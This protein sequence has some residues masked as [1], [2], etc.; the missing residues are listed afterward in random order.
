MAEEESPD[1]EPVRARKVPREDARPQSVLERQA[2][3][4]GYLLRRAQRR[5][6]RFLERSRMTTIGRELVRAGYLTGCILFDFLV[7]PEPIF[8]F[9]GDLA[10]VVTGVAFIFAIGVEAWFYSKHFALPKEESE[11]T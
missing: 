11:E 2:S 9:P 8:L 4:S 3:I 6:E 7:I 10:W 5:R 1:P